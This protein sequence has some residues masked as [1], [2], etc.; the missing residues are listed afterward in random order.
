[1]K[2]TIRCP[3]CK[4]DVPIE[5]HQEVRYDKDLSKWNKSFR[6]IKEQMQLTLSYRFQLR[7]AKVCLK[8]KWYHQVLG[9]YW[10]GLVSEKEI[11]NGV[12]YLE[13][14]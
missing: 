8:Y 10:Q 13:T 5:I 2:T 4:F 6:D 3:N 12:K 9:W 14:L 11:R 7:I 1:M